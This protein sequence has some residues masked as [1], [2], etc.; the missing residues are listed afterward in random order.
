MSTSERFTETASE[1][2][3][4]RRQV[5]ESK[6][7]VIRAEGEMAGIVQNMERLGADS[8]EA[9]ETRLASLSRKE[10][11]REAQVEKKIARLKKVMVG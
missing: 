7:E 2:A 9:A 4:M 1:L 8:L 3:D 6:D 5:D 10:K 11:Q